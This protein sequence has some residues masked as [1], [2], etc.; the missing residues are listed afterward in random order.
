MEILQKLSQYVRTLGVMLLATIF[1][2]VSSAGPALAAT[3]YETGF[4]TNGS[5]LWMSETALSQRLDDIKAL[6]ATWI[7]VDFSWYSI[8]PNNTAIYYWAMYDKVVRIATSKGLKILGIVGYPPAWAQETNCASLVTSLTAARTCNPQS[9]IAFADFVGVVAA[10]Y[11]GTNIRAWE[12]WNEP[13]LVAYWKTTMADSTLFVDPTAYATVANAAAAKIRQAY[14]DSVI[15]TGGL[16]PLFEPSAVTGMRQSDFLAQVLPKLDASLFNGIGMHPYCWPKMPTLAADYNAFYTIDA[17]RAIYNLRTIMQ[18]AGW[19]SKEIWAT[20]FGASTKGSLST[21]DAVLPQRPDHVSEAEQAL[22]IEEGVDAWF[23]KA[24]V[25]PL[26]VHSDGDQW[27][28]QHN[29]EG[30]FGLRRSDG[31][32]KPSYDAFQRA[33]ARIAQ[34]KLI[35]R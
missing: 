4:A 10:R 24:N 8:Q 11:K 5:L 18:N 17:G 9:S 3:R 6:G 13:N 25:G 29:N 16:S 27:L 12:I 22:I 2:T 19:G 1:M 14:P 31:T 30:G 15:I 32:K 23:K 7:R 35:A 33:A 21:A 20:E 26:F 34:L 28:A